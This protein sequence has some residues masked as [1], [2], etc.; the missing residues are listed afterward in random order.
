MWEREFGDIFCTILLGNAGLPGCE[1]DQER[2]SLE[3]KT[4]KT[5]GD[6]RVAAATFCGAVY[7][8]EI[9]NFQF[10]PFQKVITCIPEVPFCKA[11]KRILRT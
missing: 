3:S 9:L 10:F 4:F 2:R 11:Y 8:T 7:V 5:A 1:P 6:T